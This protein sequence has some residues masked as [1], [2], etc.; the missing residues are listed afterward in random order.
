MPTLFERATCRDALDRAWKDVAEGDSDSDSAENGRPS[1]IDRFR[2]NAEERL[3]KLAD[4]L[5]TGSYVPRDLF[6]VEIPKSSGGVRVIDV[7]AVVDRVVERAMLS[8]VTPLVDPWLGA[9]SYAYRP[10]LGVI[11][12]VHEVARLRD[13]GL[14]WALRADVDECFPTLPAARA[15]RELSAFLPDRSVDELLAALLSRRTV[16]RQGPRDVAGVPQ[17]MALS[18]LLAN[19]VLRHLDRALQ[20]EGFPVVRYAD[21]FVVA[22]SSA[23][24]AESARTVAIGALKEWEMRLGEDK[25]QIMSFTDGFAFIG[26]DFGPRYPVTDTEHRVEEPVRKTVFLGAWGSRARVREGRL[27]VQSKDDA[28]LLDVPISHVAR[29]VCFG[30]VAVSAGLR[31]WAFQHDIDMVFCSKR[32][33]YQGQHLAA[34]SP[35]R[36]VRLREQ[37]E[38]TAS[39]AV[40]TRIGLAIV[41]SKLRHQAVL[42]RRYVRPDSADDLRPHL[43][44]IDRLL[45]MLAQAATP[46]EVMG[47]EGAAALAYFDGLEVLLPPDIGFH[48]RS[49]R[50]P[51]DVVNAALGYGYAVLLGECVSALVAAGL[52][53]AFGFLH[54]DADNRPSLALDLMEE[55]RPYVVDLAVV[56]LVRK[57]SLATEHGYTKDGRTGIWL[58]KAGKETLLAAYERRM[59]QVTGGAIPG[60]RGSI[61]RH[62]YRQAQRLAGAITGGD[63]WTGLS[64]R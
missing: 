27:D 11:D 46:A 10:G 23:A 33:S 15:R 49:R 50:P 37:M 53:P 4:D 44:M 9:A 60:F 42:L 55:F 31:A 26:E 51:L 45:P 61:R 52:D 57:G 17:G 3:G 59:L 48:G 6:R 24:E 41:E 36:P 18:P 20:D 1:G 8:V 32:G 43:D 64:W 56:Q 5:A 2:K 25:T 12:A 47:V 7:P 58:T 13:E 40:A 63:P 21:D 19:V 30:P 16:T 28:T 38:A 62:L 54:R 14:G 22:C 29:I 34:T 39:T 35:R